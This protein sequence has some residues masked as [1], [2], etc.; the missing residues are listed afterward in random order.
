MILRTRK[1]WS[2]F[3]TRPVRRQL[4]SFVRAR[5]DTRP[6]LSGLELLLTRSHTEKVN[7]HDSA[8]FGEIADYPDPNSMDVDPDNKDFSESD[9]STYKDV[10]E[11]FI[12]KFLNVY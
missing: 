4:A 9:Q 10:Y 6:P 7:N 2:N 12:V 1:F 3:L 11:K 8:D 5:A